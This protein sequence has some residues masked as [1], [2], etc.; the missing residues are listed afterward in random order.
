MSAGVAMGMLARAIIASRCCGHGGDGAARRGREDSRIRGSDV[1]I[2]IPRADE[3]SSSRCSF[4][5]VSTVSLLHT[6]PPLP[7]PLYVT[8]RSCANTASVLSVVALY[9]VACESRP[10][11]RAT[12]KCVAVETAQPCGS[13]GVATA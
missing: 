2:C 1:E 8:L 12:L 9:S 13:G 7:A 11:E 6:F 3:T 5:G 4:I 10:F